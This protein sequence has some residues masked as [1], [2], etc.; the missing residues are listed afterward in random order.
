[1][2]EPM[3]VKLYDL[4]G[5]NDALRFSPFCWRTKMALRHKGITV[6]EIPW[7]FTEKETIAPTG[8]GRV[9]VLVDGDRWVHDSWAI[10][11]YL[12]TAYP[13]R[14]LMAT[15][16]ERAA[17]RFITGWADGVLHPALRPLVMLCVFEAAAE[18]DK[19]YFRKTREEML[20]A[21]LEQFCGD[22]QGALA[23]LHG[24]LS[25]LEAALSESAFLGGEAAGQ[26]D[27]VVFGSLQWGRVVNPDPLLPGGSAVEAWFDRMLDLFDGY[28][29]KTLTVRDCAN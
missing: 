25:P 16:A 14:P 12:D 11:C 17:A 5:R 24:T 3:T 10:A 6:E 22:R 20:G 2:K 27:Y 8:Q 19:A 29:R 7:R 1:M 21:T 9:P 4:A 15:R 26:S 13:E 18:R 28:G 23:N